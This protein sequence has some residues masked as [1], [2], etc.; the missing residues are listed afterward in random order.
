MADL[1]YCPD[2]TV[3]PATL[4]GS[5]AHHAI[6]VLRLKVNAA[7][8]LF[9]GRG[10]SAR[11][12][13]TSLTRRE[14][15]VEFTALTHHQPVP[16]PLTVAAAIPKGER[17]KWMVEKLAELSV[18]RFVPLL[19]ERSVVKPGHS[20]LEKLEATVVSASKQSRNYRLMSIAAPLTLPE[21]LEQ[22]TNEAPASE[23]LIAHPNA[24]PSS[25]RGSTQAGTTLMIGPEGGFT[26]DE[27]RQVCQA[28]GRAVC[29]PGA[30]LRIETAAIVFA[31]E[32]IRNS[33]RS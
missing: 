23:L 9:D 28:G 8:D 7:I 5:E 26:D 29:W 14:V 30:I 24:G 13:V 16:Q 3:S 1:F 32:V 4:T 25:S 27:V 19:A 2:L 21:L 15:V 20:K 6:N 11:G 22:S 31:A 18:V 33:R 17:L 10:Q 12:Q